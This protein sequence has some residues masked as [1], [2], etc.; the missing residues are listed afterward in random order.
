[1]PDNCNE[2]GDELRGSIRCAT[3][4]AV[5]PLALRFPTSSPLTRSFALL[6]LAIALLASACSGDDDNIGE[7]GISGGQPAPT[8][9]GRT[10]EGFA[11]GVDD[12]VAIIGVRDG[13]TLSMRVLPGGEQAIVAEI[14]ATADDLFGFGQ[15]FETP[16]EQ[17]WWL[18][19]YGD[20]QGWI[21]PG[22]AY[23]GA[24]QDISV[25]VA[26]RLERT[27]YDTM[28]ALV[29]DAQRQFG[30]DAIIVTITDESDVGDISATIDSLGSDDDTL[31][32]ERI[33][34]TANSAT[35]S[36]RLTGAQQVPLCARGVNDSGIC[37]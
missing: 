7:R 17:L 3:L 10:I 26:G 16:D 8:L 15:A 5:R 31:A 4:Q 11:P 6:L 19:R 20:A 36:Y 32:G 30:D 12:R 33:I 9:P 24:P 1:M 18:V 25:S 28:E 2:H 29:D 27:S 14:P 37:Q 23:L 21:Q 35:G 13:E 34:V 22:A